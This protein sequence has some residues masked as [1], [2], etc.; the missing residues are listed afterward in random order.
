[1]RD[2]HRVRADDPHFGWVHEDVVT[3]IVTN[4]DTTPLPW[5]APAIPTKD[6][7]QP[8]EALL[9]APDEDQCRREDPFTHRDLP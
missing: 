1:M 2:L 9:R 6:S 4:I 7:D 5:R 3:M 8:V